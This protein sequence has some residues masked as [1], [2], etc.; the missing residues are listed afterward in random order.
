MILPDGLIP[1]TDDDNSDLPE[2]LIPFNQNENFPEGLIPIDQNTITPP[3]G[4]STEPSLSGQQP[5]AGISLP[6][7]KSPGALALRKKIQGESSLLRRA[8]GD[9]LVSLAKGVVNVPR[10]IVGLADIPTGGRVGKF[11]EENTPIQFQETN[12]ILSGL[13]SPEALSSQQRVSEGFD[14][15]IMEGIKATFAN[16]SSIVSGAIEAVPS[17]F[18]GGA[19]GKGASMLPKV[20]QVFEPIAGAIGEG[21][22]TAGTGA[23]NVREASADGTLTTGQSALMAGSGVL[24]GVLGRLGSRMSQYMGGAD[25]DSIIS[26]QVDNTVKAGLLKRAIGGMVSE[27]LFEELPQS[28]QEQSLSNIAQGRPWDEGLEQSAGMGIIIGSIMGGVANGIRGGGGIAPVNPIDELRAMPDVSDIAPITNEGRMIGSVAPQDRRM[29][30]EIPEVLPPERMQGAEMVVRQRE[31]KSTID[32]EPISEATVR[33]RMLPE[34][35]ILSSYD[36]TPPDLAMMSDVDVISMARE[37]GLYREG[38]PINNLRKRLLTPEDSYAIPVRETAQVGQQQ[39]RAQGIR[40]R[41]GRRVQSQVEGEGL[42]TGKPIGVSSEVPQAKVVKDKPLVKMTVQQVRAELLDRYG[43]ETVKRDKIAELRNRLGVLRREEKFAGK[44]MER[45]GAQPSEAQKAYRDRVYQ[46]N[47]GIRNEQSY[48]DQ[49]DD[50]RGTIKMPDKTDP[51]YSELTQGIPREFFAKKGGGVPWDTKLREINSL[52]GN[53]V[54]ETVDDLSAYLKQRRKTVSQVKQ[55]MDAQERY[56]INKAEGEIAKSTI[57]DGYKT[58]TSAEDAPFQTR[59]APAIQGTDINTQRTAARDMMKPLGGQWAEGKTDTHIGTWNDGKG[60]TIEFRHEGVESPSTGRQAGQ[61]GMGKTQMAG[62]DRYVVTIDPKNGDITT[63]PHE[64]AEIVGVSAKKSL[65]KE[66]ISVMNKAMKSIDEGIDLNSS[67]GAHRFAVV[68]ETPEGRNKV[69]DT[70]LK[71]AP[72]VQQGFKKWINKVVQMVNRLFKSNIP[73]FKDANFKTIAE[74]MRDFKALNKMAEFKPIDAG[75]GGVRFQTKEALSG[76]TG[77]AREADVK[78][79]SNEEAILKKLKGEDKVEKFKDWFGA[80]W[81]E[82]NAPIFRRY[83]ADAAKGGAAERKVVNEME[84]ALRQSR[85]ASGSADDRYNEAFSGLEKAGITNADDKVKLDRYRM[86]KRI[87]EIDNNLSGKKRLERLQKIRSNKWTDKD[88]ELFMQSLNDDKIKSGGVTTNQA[89]AWLAKAQNEP[90]FKKIDDANNVIQA[91]Y[92]KSLDRLHEEGILSDNQYNA[93][94]Q[95]P[96]YQPRLFMEHFDPVVNEASNGKYTVH[97]SGIQS[98]KMGSDSPMMNDSLYLLQRNLAHTEGTI[99]R[100]KAN[101]AL[102][103]VTKAMPANTLGTKTADPNAPIPN[104]Y[105]R[106]SYRDKGET[107]SLLIPEKFAKYWKSS[108][109]ALNEAAARFF[110]HATGV[111]TVKAFATG[112]NPEFAIPSFMRD[113]GSTWFTSKQYSPYMPVAFAQQMR[114]FARAVTPSIR[115]KLEEKFKQYGGSREYLSTDTALQD[116][117][118]PDA[119][120]AGERAVK[121][122]SKAL[123]FLG[124]ETEKTTYLMLTEQALRKKDKTIATASEE[125]WKDA[126]YQASNYLDFRQHGQYTKFLDNFIP[127]ANPAAQGVRI[128]ARAFK[129][130]PATAIF[131]AAQIMA[132]GAFTAWWNRQNNEKAWESVSDSDKN[133]GA[134]F[135]LPVMAKDKEGKER[136]V[137]TRIQLDQGWRPFFVLGEM[138]AERMAGKQ[139]DPSRMRKVVIDNYNPVALTSLPPMVSALLTYTQNHDFWREDKVWKGQKVSPELEQTKNTSGVAKAVG[140]ATGM[141]PARLE[142]ASSKIMPENPLKYMAESAFNMMGK[143]DQKTN[144]DNWFKLSRVPGIRKVLRLAPSRELDDKDIKTAKKLKVAVKDRA[145]AAVLNDIERKELVV[146]DARQRNNLKF[147]EMADK[148]SSGELKRSDLMNAIHRGVK[149]EAGRPDVNEISRL[150]KRL[151]DKYPSLNIPSA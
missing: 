150:R 90:W 84:R 122:A 47:Q 104:G 101:K 124:N 25:V 55:E 134:N 3:D 123:S 105:Q 135:T 76:A 59:Q 43:V 11:I 17:M 4:V 103:D 97:D 80:S 75:E 29:M 50:V 142:S 127:F 110:R 99:A 27:G 139:V 79:A 36:R 10:S 125:D 13:Y 107:K 78:M 91:E 18:A 77:E 94:I 149:T 51:L 95:S 56:D 5:Q 117:A 24:T 66:Y 8:V 109:P 21:L 42:A 143:E 40:P 61:V 136:A 35:G 32:V 14:K 34:K 144:E 6:E 96:D 132:L 112:L 73:E 7:D 60:T 130:D 39:N 57:T 46:Q 2:G 102:Y 92:R 45:A 131:K 114:N 9:P 82:W 64:L 138:A 54:G 129:E 38:E 116:I 128:V 83:R 49:V 16:P 1:I 53:N 106:I 133:I 71:A 141:S 23:E 86:A 118:K 93:L 68:M 137:S 89:K 12:K 65:S 87:V 126:V 140:E 44:R 120:S 62:K 31:P 100:N 81:V 74:G 69:A 148:V 151:R 37:R 52:S 48:L 41:E 108:D 33:G 58:W 111:S 115:K 88:E 30:P 147:D 19:L 15:G 85:G 146:N 72:G 121:Q 113:L 119:L 22:A 67:D 20:G 63:P 26:G 145:P 70:L 98:L 28:I